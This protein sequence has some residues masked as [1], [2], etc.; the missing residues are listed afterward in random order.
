M[1]R[2]EPTIS[3]IDL[4]DI[5]YGRNPRRIIEK[6]RKPRSTH[7]FISAVV[8]L[9]TVILLKQSIVDISITTDRH[10]EPNLFRGDI[11]VVNKTSYGIR[12]P[13]LNTLLFATDEPAR[14]DLVLH[15]LKGERDRQ[16]IHRVMGLPGDKISY[17]PKN[18]QLVV[19]GEKITKKYLGPYDQHNKVYK[20]LF[21]EPHVNILESKTPFKWKD[22]DWLGTGI[23][24]IPAN[25]YFLMTDNR[26]FCCDSRQWGLVDHEDLKGKVTSVK[27]NIAKFTPG[28]QL[29]ELE[30]R[31]RYIRAHK[32]SQHRN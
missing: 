18:G 4:I 5:D 29:S 7:R 26:T 1:E 25:K 16:L 20:E 30:A 22:G 24:E 27:V 12:A 23:K 21:L 13:F 31:E 3:N 2:K 9:T 17:F 6:E 10:M 15:I 19:N 8:L 14:G 28:I 11:V 32:D